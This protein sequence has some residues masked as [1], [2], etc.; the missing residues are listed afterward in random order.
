MHP[1]NR[2]KY[3]KDKSQVRKKTPINYSVKSNDTYYILNLFNIN[4]LN[5]FK[6]TF[7]KLEKPTYPNEAHPLATTYSSQGCLK[8]GSSLSAGRKMAGGRQPCLLWQ[9][10]PLKWT[11]PIYSRSILVKLGRPRERPFLQILKPAQT[12]MK[13][14]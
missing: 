9:R 3:L 7:R 12:H 5:Q 1:R 10:L 14:F 11:S 4:N 13:G 8:T 2:T 6:S